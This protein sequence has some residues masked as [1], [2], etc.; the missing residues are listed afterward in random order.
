MNIAFMCVGSSK[1]IVKIISTS[2]H[3]PLLVIKHGFIGMTQKQTVIIRVED[4]KFWD[5]KKCLWFDFWHQ[6]HCPQRIYSLV[7]DSELAI[8]LWCFL[9]ALTEQFWQKHYEKWAK[10]TLDVA[11]WECIGPLSL[12]MSVSHCLTAT[13]MTA[14][15]HP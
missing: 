12:I 9:V 13:N 3:R 1:N 10:Q 15:L 4:T 6:R 11:S 7:P 2:F 5:H 14:I 8:L